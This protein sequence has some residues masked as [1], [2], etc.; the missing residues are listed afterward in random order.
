MSGAGCIIRAEEVGDE[1]AVDAL[2]RAAFGGPVEAGLVRRLRADGDV[3]LALVAEAGRDIVGHI[4]FSPLTGL[5]PVHAA[6]L[7]P[8]AVH[9]SRQRAGIGTALVREGLVQLRAMGVDVV[10]VLGEPGYYGR[11]GFDAER[12]RAFRTPYDGPYLQAL[13]LSDAG[14]AARGPLHY[15]AA[16]AAL[17]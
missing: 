10:L 9:P 14:G 2:L 13:A 4:L 5:A 15:A 16:F 12:A 8:L 11:F 17:G 3:L 7:A 6:A 1:A